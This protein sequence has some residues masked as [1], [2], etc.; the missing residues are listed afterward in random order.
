MVQSKHE[1]RDAGLPAERERIKAAIEEDLA[2]DP[3]ILA[4]F[5]GG[6]V[7]QG[8]SDS[9]S[10]IDLRII[11]AD[12]MYEV[13]R[14]KMMQRAHRWGNILFVEN[15]SFA[16]YCTIHYESFVKVDLFQYRLKDVL[17]SF[18]LRHI[19]IFYDATGLLEDVVR[20]SKELVF[21]PAIEDVQFWRTK[22]FA[23][24]H[25]L[26]RRVM[27][28]ELYYALSCLDTMR[29]LMAVAWYMEKGIQPNA[30]GDWAKIEGERSLLSAAQKEELAAWDCGRDE[31]EL[32]A[33]AERIVSSFKLVHASLCD[34]VGL[35]VDEAWIDRIMQQVF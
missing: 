1:G 29:F 28:G 9:Y 11:V 2:G 17:P 23:S 21:D 30:L 19:E 4:L 20:K 34:Q 25:E 7:G 5:Y 22:F 31:T 15:M 35:A 26:Y 10:D 16:H 32:M 6:S 24:V 12:D 14:D 13:Y 27:R 33:V 18:W 3:S 8:N